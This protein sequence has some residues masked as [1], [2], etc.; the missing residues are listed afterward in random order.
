MAGLSRTKTTSGGVTIPIGS[1]VN[2]LDTANVVT[3]SNETFLKNGQLSDSSTYPNAPLRNF[4]NEASLNEANYSSYLSP[5]GAS[6]TSNIVPSKNGCAFDKVNNKIYIVTSD[7]YLH[8]LSYTSGTDTTWIRRDDLRAIIGT[9]KYTYLAGLQYI[10]S[11]SDISNMYGTSNTAQE[12]H[13]ALAVATVNATQVYISTVDVSGDTYALKSGTNQ[14]LL[15]ANSASGASNMGNV[16]YSAVCWISPTRIIYAAYIAGKF[17]SS[18]YNALTG[19]FIAGQRNDSYGSTSSVYQFSLVPELVPYYGGRGTNNTGGQAGWIHPLYTSN[20]VWG[21]RTI[22]TI[23]VVRYFV[24]Q[25][26]QTISSTLTIDASFPHN[27]YSYNSPHYDENHGL[28]YLTMTSHPLKSYKY[29]SLS[30]VKR[31]YPSRHSGADYTG[32]AYDGSAS[33][34]IGNTTENKIFRIHPTTYALTTA[35]TITTQANYPPFAFVGDGTHIYN[36]YGDGSYA[37]KVYKYQIS[38]G[39]NI[40]NYAIDSYITGTNVAGIARDS[41]GNFY[42]LDKSDKQLHKWNSSWVYQSYVALASGPDGAF[43][44]GDI[45]CDGTDFFVFDSTNTKILFFLADGTYGGSF[46]TANA[47]ITGLDYYSST[48][49]TMANSS[50]TRSYTLNKNATGHPTEAIT[51]TTSQYTRVA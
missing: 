9:S 38:N 15:T 29:D 10:P 8:T 35:S 26:G 45:A 13:A 14:V 40:A 23:P 2:L 31:T 49:L 39:A 28:C 6:G 34:F 4:M 27:Q 5:W 3:R 16:G 25:Y 1:Q 21:V 17:H 18:E 42:I 19:A 20:H 32:Y 12:E 37:P 43:T 30:T 22:S 24:N 7:Y 48:L 46:A 11:H 41:A 44:P 36:V 33:I 50:Q 47:N 51:A